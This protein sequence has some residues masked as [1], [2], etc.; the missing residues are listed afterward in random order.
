MAAPS[1]ISPATDPL[2]PTSLGDWFEKIIELI[3]RSFVRLLVI[4][5]GL[6]VVIAVLGAI[7]GALVALLVWD[8]SASRSATAGLNSLIFVAVFIVFLIVSA[9]VQAASFVIAVLD[10]AGEPI[11]VG[12]ALRFT[13][14]RVLPLTGWMI[15]SGIMT[16]V[17]FALLVIPGI[18]LM[19][20]FG[21]SLIGVVTV[22]RRNI[23]R[24]FEL[25]NRRFWPT[26]GRMSV[27]FL[28]FVVYITVLIGIDYIAGPNSFVSSVL[29]W[30]FSIVIGLFAVGVSVVTYAELRFH[31]NP[32]VLTP[33]LVAELRR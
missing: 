27:V 13:R 10:A 8:Q 15:I 19:I 7:A 24:S 30:I 17:G 29:G 25:V 1:P 11:S 3:R 20:V 23:N 32:T 26:T 28:I 18:Y 6:T 12:A 2:V 9:W 14:G 33:T 16:I 5:I 22:E 31:E 21:A 4:Q